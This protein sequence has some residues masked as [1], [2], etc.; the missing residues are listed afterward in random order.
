MADKEQYIYNAADIDRYLNGEMTIKEMHDMERAALGDPFLFDAIEG[1]RKADRRQTTRHLNE[2]SAAIHAKKPPVKIIEMRPKKTY[3]WQIG[4]AAAAIIVLGIALF[5]KQSGNEVIA[6][7]GK[8][9]TTNKND[10]TIAEM[11]LSPAPDSLLATAKPVDSY[12]AN[13]KSKIIRRKKELKTSGTTSYSNEPAIALSSPQASKMQSSKVPDTTANNIA[14]ARVSDY[15]SRLASPPNKRIILIKEQPF[16]LSQIE[17]ISL[18]QKRKKPVDTASL[19]PEGG[20]QNFQDYLFGKLTKKDSASSA[21][22]AP[23]DN[24]LELEFSLN[25]SGFPYDIQVLHAGD[26]LLAKQAVS[27]VRDG[28]KWA[29]SD[30]KKKRINLSY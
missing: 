25:E 8:Q 27:A 22:S 23:F 20:W 10:T 16:V 4:V 29:S 1:F 11:Q 24:R 14:M 2:I 19:K 21:N 13:N 30:K 5:Y 6:L 26:S 7:A 3:R 12:L 18:G 28:P 17:E 9:K 15:Q